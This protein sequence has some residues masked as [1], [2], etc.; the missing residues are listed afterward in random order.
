MTSIVDEREADYGDASVNMRRTAELWSAYL[1]TPITAHD[2]SICMILVKCSRAKVT[3]R[4]DNYVDIAG[5]AKIAD[6][7]W[8]DD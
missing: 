5:Y 6:S 2:V 3:H 1:Q 7:V 8:S 4:S